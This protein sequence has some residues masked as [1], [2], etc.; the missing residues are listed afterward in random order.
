MVSILATIKA[1]VFA[2][3]VLVM[4][5]TMVFLM[6]KFVLLAAGNR[7]HLKLIYVQ[8]FLL[9][10]DRPL[11]SWVPLRSVKGCEVVVMPVFP[12][13]QF[14]CFYSFSTVLPRLSSG[15]DRWLPLTSCTCIC[16]SA[17]RVYVLINGVLF[18]NAVQTSGCFFANFFFIALGNSCYLSR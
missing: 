15:S 6:P 5:P 14:A 12:L 18:A 9:L 13:F 16:S 2:L 7:M 8:K 17:F 1:I 3:V 10:I 4:L 11:Q